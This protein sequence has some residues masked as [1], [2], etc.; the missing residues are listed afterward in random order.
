LSS[1]PPRPGPLFNDPGP[2]LTDPGP[3]LIEPGPR[4]SMRTTESSVLAVVCP[5]AGDP[6]T[7]RPAI[8]PSTTP[9]QLVSRS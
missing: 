4:L 5:I 1:R 9:F 2:L 8:T 3:L 7:V 6:V